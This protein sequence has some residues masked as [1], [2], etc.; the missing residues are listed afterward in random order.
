MVFTPSFVATALFAVSVVAEKLLTCGLAGNYYPSQYTCFDYDFLCPIINGTVYIQCGN[1]CYSNSQYSC[2]NGVIEPYN[3]NGPVVLELCGDTQYDLSQFVCL[4]SE[5]DGFL[6][7]V[8]NGQAMLVCDFTCYQP[9]QYDCY[10]N[11][12]YPLDTPAPTCVPEFGDDEI[13]N[14][15]GCFILPCCPGL[16]SVAN[17]CRD[18]CQLAPQSCPNTTAI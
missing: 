14:D 3:P 8:V 1:A 2:S 10:L 16:I 15:E 12:I 18:P 13:C 9:E 7:P 11:Q 17:K 4:N 6:C 5:P